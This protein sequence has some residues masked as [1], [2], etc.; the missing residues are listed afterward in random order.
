MA[1]SGGAD[2]VALLHLL[3]D[4]DGRG[5]ADA[6]R[7][8]P[9]APRPARRRRRRGSGFLRGPDAHGSASRSTTARVDVAA[10]AREQKRSVEDAAP[11]GT[12][13]ISRGG[14]RSPVGRHDRDRAHARRPG[15][16]VSPSPAARIRHSGAR[17]HQAA[18]RP[19]RAA[20]A[21]R[22][23]A[24]ICGAI[25]RIDRKTSA[26]MPR[27]RMSRCSATVCG[28]SCCRFWNHG[29]RPGSQMCW[30]ARPPLRSR[31][32]TFFAVNAI[33]TARRIVL[34]DSGR[35][36]DSLQIDARA[37]TSVSPA[38]ASRVAHDVLS[39]LAGPRPITFDHVRRLLDLAGGGHDHGTLS[40]PGQHAERVG[41]VVVLRRGRGVPNGLLPN[42]FAFPLSIPGEV[43]RRPTAGPFARN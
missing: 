31:T 40:L 15:G 3:R 19:G 33:E 42:T 26:R 6:R 27:T 43:A 22:R 35:S 34:S 23:R 12:I 21:G 16:D 38:L 37:L 24:P 29:F 14:R 10:L 25:L 13:R 41:K 7:R 18:R 30:R 2:S 28:T 1:L 20:A 39:R 5:R 4:L 36:D 9:P 32:K 17:R 11:P 8:R